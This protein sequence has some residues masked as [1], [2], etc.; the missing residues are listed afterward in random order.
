MM[1]FTQNDWSKR[2][3]LKSIISLT[4]Q[5]TDTIHAVIPMKYQNYPST[6]IL[7][8]ANVLSKVNKLPYVHSLN[9]TPHGSYSITIQLRTMIT[10]GT[11]HEKKE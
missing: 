8:H 11:N 4:K 3:I 2:D 7:K 5:G 10:L 6:K 9:M 1:S